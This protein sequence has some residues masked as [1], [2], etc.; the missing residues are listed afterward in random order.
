M[1]IRMSGNSLLH[2]CIQIEKMY[3]TSN[4][5]PCGRGVNSISDRGAV[6]N[7]NAGATAV[8]PLQSSEPELKNGSCLC[9]EEVARLREEFQAVWTQRDKLSNK[10]VSDYESVTDNDREAY[11]RLCSH[12]RELQGILQEYRDVYPLALPS[13]KQLT[14]YGQILFE[15]DE[16][17]DGRFYT[18]EETAA[19]RAELLAR[20]C[21]YHCHEGVIGNITP[22]QTTEKVRGKK[23]I[24]T[25]WKAGCAGHD[26]GDS[27]YPCNKVHSGEEYENETLENTQ[28]SV[29]GTGV[30][31]VMPD[32]VEAVGT[33]IPRALTVG[34]TTSEPTR[35]VA[36]RLVEQIM[37]GTALNESTGLCLGSNVDA[38]GVSTERGQHE[39][40][41]K[42][43][44]LDEEEQDCLN[45]IDARIDE[46]NKNGLSRNLNKVVNCLVNKAFEGPGECYGE[47]H[48][49]EGDRAEEEGEE[50]KAPYAEVLF[51]DAFRPF[52]QRTIFWE[53]LFRSVRGRMLP[54]NGE[55]HS[56]MNTLKVIR[57]ELQILIKLSG[58]DQKK[59]SKQI[60]NCREKICKIV[61]RVHEIHDLWIEYSNR[62]DV[63]YKNY[64]DALK[65]QMYYVD[66]IENL[67]PGRINGDPERGINPHVEED[68]D[69][70]IRYMKYNMLDV[71]IKDFLGRYMTEVEKKDLEHSLKVLIEHL[72]KFDCM[73]DRRKNLK[74]SSVGK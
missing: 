14:T 28:K 74:K 25:V 16:I 19:K 48:N 56:L 32:A 68:R 65:H 20:M 66:E 55:L 31:P 37:S 51:R 4:A 39:S 22:A 30:G 60:E 46:I 3:S 54:L 27:K 63:Y 26:H 2:N 9:A 52:E 34:N 7:A 61:S 36:E 64:E 72:Q 62:C 13:E 33:T 21:P 29:I 45:K 73:I 8:H 69:I 71:V 42:L 11:T 70:W 17:T 5:T 38:G 50:N 23:V 24:K 57:D 18:E 59:H 10:F 40:N 15:E 43:G 35:I 41:T 44:S 49:P 58:E 47:L 12:W 53:S 1:C 67:V 6:V